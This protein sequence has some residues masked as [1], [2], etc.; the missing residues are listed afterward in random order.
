[1]T[2]MRRT[3]TDDDDDDDVTICITCII[4]IPACCAH[5]LISDDLPHPGGPDN[6]N[7]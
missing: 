1:M 6:S 3:R 7:I 5:T 2:T 4:F